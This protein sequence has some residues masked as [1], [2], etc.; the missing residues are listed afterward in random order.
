M[1]K[2]KKKE[3]S[4]PRSSSGPASRG[5]RQGFS[6]L[7]EEDSGPLN[8]PLTSY[9]PEIQGPTN[10]RYNFEECEYY[11]KNADGG[12][13]YLPHHPTPLSLRYDA[14]PVVV[15]CLNPEHGVF[16]ILNSVCS[17]LSSTSEDTPTKG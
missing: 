10:E 17:A 14:D 3:R 4:F 7:A 1:Q 13:W 11:Q 2:S 6:T 12:T 9:L 16:V 8:R 5:S 15:C